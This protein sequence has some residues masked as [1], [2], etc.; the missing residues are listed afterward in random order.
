LHPL[1]GRRR[2]GCAADLAGLLQNQDAQAGPGQVRR[3][4]QAVVS[5]A[6]DDGIK[7]VSAVIVM[8]ALIGMRRS[9][10]ASA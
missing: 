10:H 4:D 7:G 5:A 3:G 9:R 6:D 2:H 1:E 8:G